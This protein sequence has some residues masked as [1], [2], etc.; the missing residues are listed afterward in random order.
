MAKRRLAVL[1]F[2]A[3]VPMAL[4]TAFAI[5]DIWRLSAGR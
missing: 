4:G 2:L 5:L 1:L 3:I